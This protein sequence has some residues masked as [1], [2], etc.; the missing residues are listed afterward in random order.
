MS[1]ILMLEVKG[2]FA[3]TAA[4]LCHVNA[5]R[6]A[7]AAGTTTQLVPHTPLTNTVTAAAAAAAAVIVPSASPDTDGNKGH[8]QDRLAGQQRYPGHRHREPVSQTAGGGGRRWK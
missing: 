5:G 1:L 8:E 2:P 7:A 3:A 6:V 4:G